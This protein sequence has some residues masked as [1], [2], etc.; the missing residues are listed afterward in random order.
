MMDWLC[1]AALLGRLSARSR[2]NTRCVGLMSMRAN[3]KV[4]GGFV[5]SA[6]ALAAAGILFFGG[7]RFFA[8]TDNYVLFFGGSAKG[9]NVG[10]PVAF[11]GVKIGSVT[12]IRLLYDERDKSFKIM[13][14]IATEPKAVTQ[15]HTEN[16]AQTPAPG[17]AKKSL[18]DT[19][20]AA[21]LRAQ[22]GMQSLVTGQLYVELDFHPDSPVRLVGLHT[23]YQE[24][25]TIPSKLE[26]LTKTV[27]SLPL[28]EIV[29]KFTSALEGIER[30]INSP[31]SQEILVSLEATVKEAQ[32]V[33]HNI[34]E[35]IAPLASGLDGTFADARKLLRD[36]D[37]QVNPLAGEIKAAA[38]ETRGLVT[39]VDK[40][41]GPL[42]SSIEES[43]KAAHSA[44]KQAESTLATV[45]GMTGE[46][47]SLRYEL[48]N[49]LKEL[50]TAARA[51][52]QLSDYLERHPEALLQGKAKQGGK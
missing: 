48:T 38:R 34:N 18:I 16:G 39:N 2:T 20:I 43:F 26:Q 21:G 33:L 3:A 32:S 8:K 22:L 17:A 28:E 37:G 50:S 11:K 13:V 4:V 27:E 15:I 6:L 40:R 36:I 12:D 42:T 35:R 47:S 41:L 7:G 5:V 24:L 1:R 49:A 29:A 9:L 31:H 10:A 46:S 19:L 30:F 51:I 25:P 52:R 23:Y 44:L 14:T 45:E